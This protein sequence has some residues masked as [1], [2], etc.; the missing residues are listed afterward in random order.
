VS[1]KI[2]PELPEARE[3]ERTVQPERTDEVVA[4][5]ERLDQVALREGLGAEQDAYY[6]AIADQFEQEWYGSREADAQHAQDLQHMA[7]AVDAFARGDLLEVGAGSGHWTLRCLNAGARVTVVEPS[8]TMRS[9]T[10]RRLTGAGKTARLMLGRSEAIPL[11]DHKMDRCLLAFVLSHLD[12]STREATFKEVVRVVRPG[13]ELLMMDSLRHDGDPSVQVVRRIVNGQP[14]RVL[15]VYLRPEEVATMIDP[16]ARV[17]EMRTL[18]HAW[19]LRVRL[20]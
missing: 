4:T 2:T 10:R 8:E 19:I 12:A 6:V 16:I 3:S 15:K 17:Q 20:I 18:N 11:G 7:E 13:G 9:V 14:F 1:S 5:Y